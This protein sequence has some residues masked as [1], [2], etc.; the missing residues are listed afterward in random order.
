MGTHL[1]FQKQTS[2]VLNATKHYKHYNF[3]CNRTR[4]PKH[5]VTCRDF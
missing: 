4:I 1:G 3:S 5:I 2:I